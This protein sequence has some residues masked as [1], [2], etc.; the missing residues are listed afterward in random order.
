MR[1]LDQPHRRLKNVGDDLHPHATARAAVGSQKPPR[2]KADFR[3]HVYVMTKAESD[4]FEKRAPEMGRTMAETEAGEGSPRERILD[5]RL[6]AEEIGQAKHA[7]AA[8]RDRPG[9][10]I[11]R[12]MGIFAWGVEA[13]RGG[14]PVEGRAG[15]RHAAVR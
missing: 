7:V 1:I 15:R 2:R 14:E 9:K 6:L 11:E 8:G 5:R 10:T 3:K 13:E 4:R 12:G